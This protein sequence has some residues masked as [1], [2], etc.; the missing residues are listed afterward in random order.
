MRHDD[1]AQKARDII[2]NVDDLR[3]CLEQAGMPDI[4]IWEV[5]KLPTE[6]ELRAVIRALNDSEQRSKNGDE[7]S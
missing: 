3:R 7:E 4:P 1:Y 6:E 2:H 5:G